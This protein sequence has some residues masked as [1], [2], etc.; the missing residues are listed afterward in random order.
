MRTGPQHREIKK[1]LLIAAAAL[2]VLFLWFLFSEHGLLDSHRLS[3]QIS[4]TRK[5]NADLEKNNQAL[6]E[7]INKLENDSAYLTEIARKQELL[8]KNEIIFDFR[9]PKKNE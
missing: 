6:K 2:L 9:Q 5:D 1:L 3:Q 4:S 7:E 8:K